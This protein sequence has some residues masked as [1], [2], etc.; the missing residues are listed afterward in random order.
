ML[1]NKEHITPVFN[2]LQANLTDKKGLFQ[3][4]FGP[5]ITSAALR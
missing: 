2:G 1:L 4:F 5:S 3:A